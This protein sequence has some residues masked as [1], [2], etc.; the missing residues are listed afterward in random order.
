MLHGSTSPLSGRSP[1]SK[2]LKKTPTK[3]R[4]SLSESVVVGDDM[5]HTRSLI[6]KWIQHFGL[7]SDVFHVRK[8]R[9]QQHQS[10]GSAERAVRRLRESLAV[11]RADINTGGWDI[12]FDY[13]NLQ[14]ALIYVGLWQK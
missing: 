13:E 10:L 1:F 8:C 7:E 5:S 4:C 12:K 2:K 9:N 11:V 6:L 3:P 14:E